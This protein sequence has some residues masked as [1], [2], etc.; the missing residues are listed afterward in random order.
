[1]KKL[2]GSIVAL[3]QPVPMRDGCVDFARGRRELW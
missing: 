1:M 3:G 2:T